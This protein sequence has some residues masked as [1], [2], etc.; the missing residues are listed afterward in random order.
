VRSAATRGLA[1]GVLAATA[2]AT[3]RARAEDPAPKTW[4][5]L[6]LGAIAGPPAKHVA[7][8]GP[9]EHTSELHV[10]AIDGGGGGGG[11]GVELFA[12]AEEMKAVREGATAGLDGCFSEA[13]DQGGTSTWGIGDTRLVVWTP[14][15]EGVRPVHAERLVEDDGHENATLEFLDAW[16]DPRTRGARVIGRSKLPLVRI[17]EAMADV[18]VYAAREESAAGKT[19]HVVVKRDGDGAAIGSAGFELEGRLRGRGTCGHMRVALRADSEAGD[20]SVVRTM[21][22]LGR[23]PDAPPEPVEIRA[24]EV[25][26]QLG[27]SKTTRDATP[28]V[29]VSFGWSGREQPFQS[30]GTGRFVKKK[31]RP[32]KK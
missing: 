16:V 13:M 14:E 12:S 4:S 9:G 25:E 20:V 23:T 29:S 8:V 27:A 31:A 28:I 17:G 15:G 24:R 2:L 22:A 1:L 18:R 7:W 19:L 10:V 32:R 6:P 26:V 5:D 21:V 11:H 3:T 30:F